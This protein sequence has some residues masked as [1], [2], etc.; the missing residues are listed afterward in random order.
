MK[1]ENTPGIPEHLPRT[2]TIVQLSFDVVNGAPDSSWQIHRWDYRRDPVNDARHRLKR[3]AAR[4][5]YRLPPS[6]T[7]CDDPPPTATASVMDRHPECWHETTDPFGSGPIRPRQGDLIMQALTTRTH[8]VNS[9]PIAPQ[10]PTMWIA[11]APTGAHGENHDGR[12]LP[13]DLVTRL[14][15]LTSIL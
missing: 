2:A 8:T 7:S 6:S 15:T 11:G 4:R 1:T 14:M 10:I 13:F 9:T 5:T 12:E 3:A